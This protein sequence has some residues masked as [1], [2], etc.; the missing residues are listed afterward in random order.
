MDDEFPKIGGHKVLGE[1]GDNL[2]ATALAEGLI[3]FGHKKSTIAIHRAMEN[4]EPTSET[5]VKIF[6]SRMLERYKK[7]TASPELHRKFLNA[8]ADEYTSLAQNEA[9]RFDALRP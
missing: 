1:I 3:R 2:G 9:Q 5:E 8:I 7:Y 6:G 4:I